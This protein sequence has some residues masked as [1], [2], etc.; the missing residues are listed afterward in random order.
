MSNLKTLIVL[1]CTALCSHG[2]HAQQRV[3]GIEELFLLADENSQSI[4][5][6]QPSQSESQ[7]VQRNG[8]MR[9]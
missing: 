8:G 1:C 5:T 6:E 3:M 2:L 4:Q 7:D 9:R